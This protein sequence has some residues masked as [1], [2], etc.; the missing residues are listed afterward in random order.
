MQ[1]QSLKYLIYLIQY[2]IIVALLIH[3]EFCIEHLLFVC[4]IFTSYNMLVYCYF[5]FDNTLIISFQCTSTNILFFLLAIAKSTLS[6]SVEYQPIKIIVNENFNDSP[7]HGEL[8]PLGSN[9]VHQGANFYFN[10]EVK[11]PEGL[12]PPHI[13]ALIASLHKKDVTIG[14]VNK[15]EIVLDKGETIDAA[16]VKPLEIIPEA[17]IKDDINVVEAIHVTEKPLP[18]AIEVLPPLPI[19]ETVGIPVELPELEPVELVIEEEETAEP[20]EVIPETIIKDDVDVVETVDVNEKPLLSAVEVLP[21]VNVAETIGVPLELPVMEPIE[22]EE[23]YLTYPIVEEPE[24]IVHELVPMPEAPVLPPLSFD[25]I[26]PV[27]TEEVKVEE[28][29]NGAMP[30]VTVTE[31]PIFLEKVEEILPVMPSLPAAPILRP[32]VEPKLEES[33]IIDKVMEPNPNLNN[34]VMD[35]EEKR[36][37]VV[38][39][40]PKEIFKSVVDEKESNSKFLP[41]Y[42]I[43]FHNNGKPTFARLPKLDFVRNEK[44]QK[45]PYVISKS[46]APYT[47]TQHITPNNSKIRGQPPKQ[48]QFISLPRDLKRSNS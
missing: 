28:P 38:I 20:I 9:F 19:A 3:F 12:L 42:R 15:P 24:V 17:I 4:S 13:E 41:N 26:P 31:K 8:P 29:I 46:R 33:F 36:E 35:V 7:N 45:T 44:I 27:I 14:L 40:M 23:D 10:P 22:V 6:K 34:I 2:L 16:V 32:L 18:G 25:F 48:I 30:C 11:L 47:V 21:P 1:N 39:E 37:P 5:Y 43:V